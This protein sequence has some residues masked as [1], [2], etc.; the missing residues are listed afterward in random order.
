MK[1]RN[2]FLF[3][4]AFLTSLTFSSTLLNFNSINILEIPPISK[5]SN[6]DIN[7]NAILENITGQCNSSIYNLYMLENTTYE[8][9][10][11]TKNYTTMI[12]A[13]VSYSTLELGNLSTTKISFAVTALTENFTEYAIANDTSNAMNGTDANI[14]TLAQN[15]SINETSHIINFGLFLNYTNTDTLIGELAG[16]VSIDIYKAGRIGLGPVNPEEITIGLINS[17]GHWTS[18]WISAGYNGLLAKGNYTMHFS[19][20]SKDI[21]NNSWQIQNYSNPSDD[22][23]GSMFYNN[24]GWFPIDNDGHAD[25]LLNMSI[26]PYIHPQAANLTIYV[27]NNNIP[28][29][30]Y[31]EPNLQ[32]D[33]YPWAGFGEYFLPNKPNSPINLTISLNITV[34]VGV[35]LKTLRFYRFEP[36]NGTYTASLTNRYWEVNYTSINSTSEMFPLFAFPSDWSIYTFYGRFGQEVQEYGLMFS[37]IYNRS[38]SAIYYPE[39]TGGSGQYNYSVI[40][41]SPNYVGSIKTQIRSGNDYIDQL[42]F[43]V[44]NTFRIQAGIV[45]YSSSPVSG[46]NCTFYIFDS[47]ENL[48]YNESTT[49]VNGLANSSDIKIEDVGAGEYMVVVTWTNGSEVGVNSYTFS[50]LEEPILFIPPLSTE[51]PI[52]LYVITTALV[53]A[54]VG[55]GGVIVRRK[56]LERNWEKSLLHLFIMTKDGRSLYNYEF[57]TEAKDPSLISGMLTALTSFVQETVGSKKQLKTIDQEDKKVILG[58]GAD[59]TVAVFAEKDLPIIHSRTND[60]LKAF[61][62]YYAG[63]IQKWDGSSITFK[64]AGELVEKYF[65]VSVEDKIIRAVGVQLSNIKEQINK[66]E[67]AQE[68]LSLLHKTTELAEKYQNIIQKHLSKEYGEIIKIANEKIQF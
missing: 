53:V 28:L 59:C 58:H 14:M 56:M 17:S 11:S 42:N 32:Y 47:S 8:P 25:F 3:I 34:G 20:M 61:E 64:S 35:I 37:V 60:F 24:S 27:D 67:D 40:F 2:I 29:F 38:Y 39:N 68:I 43:Y 62:T 45:D 12:P 10:L 18:R 4:V 55:V 33:K 7:I 49:S 46:G 15:F 63:K 44:G 36:A 50:L 31:E 65:P 22:K 9:F 57:G 26:A 51:Q 23:G 52:W 5:K 54:M 21:N 16:F 13:N 6:I 30:Y 48:I 1:K 19:I 41:L 66:T